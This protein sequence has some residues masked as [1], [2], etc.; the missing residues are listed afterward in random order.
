M[1]I[2]SHSDV[3]FKINGRQVYLKMENTKEVFNI[4]ATEHEETMMGMSP[5]FL[6]IGRK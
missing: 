2:K 1:Y 4:Y 6:V 5:H 3:L